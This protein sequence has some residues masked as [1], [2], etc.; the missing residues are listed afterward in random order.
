MILKENKLEGEECMNLTK[1][2]NMNILLLIHEM[3]VI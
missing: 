3:I 2:K 1:L